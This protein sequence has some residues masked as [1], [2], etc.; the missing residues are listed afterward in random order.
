MDKQNQ[1][2]NIPGQ[3]QA[4]PKNFWQKLKF[5]IYLIIFGIILFFVVSII[6]ALIF[7]LGSFNLT[8]GKNNISVGFP[9]S[10]FEQ[11]GCPA[12]YVPEADEYLYPCGCSNFKFLS[13]PFILDL[14]IWIIIVY[15]I[16]LLKVYYKKRKSKNQN[17]KC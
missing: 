9:I 1:K 11:I 6:S 17:T 16:M 12:E 14:I 13:V 3:D 7:E 8:T 4:K 10:C 2:I 15:F 5:I